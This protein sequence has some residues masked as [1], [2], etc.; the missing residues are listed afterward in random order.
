MTGVWTAIVEAGGLPVLVLVSFM[1]A[2]FV[3]RVLGFGFALVVLGMLPAAFDAA[4][5]I[6]PG[7]RLAHLT[8]SLAAVLPLVVMVLQF[9]QQIDRSALIVTILGAAIG[10]PLGLLVFEI[11][12]PQSLSRLT[13]A[14]LLLL[15]WDVWRRKPEEIAGL[16]V[17]LASD[18]AAY[19]TGSTYFM[20]GGML[21]Q[22]GSY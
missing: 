5:T 19:V 17:F 16:A 4:G 9:H 21:R 22:S 7:V 14:A 20:D 11:M 12:T 13:G 3:Q 2:A 6:L 15:V 1:F 18:E 10:L 8:S